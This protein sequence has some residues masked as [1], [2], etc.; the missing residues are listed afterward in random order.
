MTGVQT[1]AL[2]ICS[3][4]AGAVPGAKP[5]TAGIPATVQPTEVRTGATTGS[6]QKSASLDN[7]ITKLAKGDV[8]DLNPAI[9]NKRKQLIKELE[10]EKFVPDKNPAPGLKANIFDKLRTPAE[11]YAKFGQGK[12]AEALR[13][14][15]I[16]SKREIESH[17]TQIQNWVQRV[18]DRQEVVFDALDGKK[19]DLTPDEAQVV[20]EIQ[21]YFATWADRLKLPKDRRVTDYITHIFE[22]DLLKKE[23]DPDLARLI[24]GQ[25][26]GS[27]YDPF[28]LA[29]KGAIKYKKDI[30]LALSAYAKRGVR[31]R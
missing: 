8:V 27:V 18:G 13:L 3:S 31:D 29:R 6:L 12:A 25:V 1:C 14:S 10:T 26:P 30:G 17:V 11:V 4:L 5:L 7:P 24:E 16:Q 22:D 19:V 9:I 20:A 2:P 15:E 28:L 23:F 21:D